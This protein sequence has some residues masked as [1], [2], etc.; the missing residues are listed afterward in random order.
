MADDGA[1]APV[2]PWHHVAAELDRREAVARELIARLTVQHDDLVVA[3]AG[4]NADDE[5]DPEG[6]T[7]AWDREQTAALVRQ[8]EADVA[9]LAAAR[10]RLA[11]GTYGVCEVCGRPI[12]A[13]RL[14]ARPTARAC[15]TC[16]SRR[17]A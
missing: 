3:A 4:A 13:E 14:A 9:E 8:T 17:P 6:A 11:A 10:A 12:A 16:A 15:I 5:H 7:L 1:D 2:G